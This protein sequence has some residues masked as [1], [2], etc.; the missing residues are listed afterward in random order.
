MFGLVL[1]VDAHSR[2]RCR[3][4]KRADNAAVQLCTLYNSVL[5]KAGHPVS[6]RHFSEQPN[7]ILR[8]SLDFSVVIS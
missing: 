1:H 8:P 4:N 5:L 6:L 2:L 3:R 7:F